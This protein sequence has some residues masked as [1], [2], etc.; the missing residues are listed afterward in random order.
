MALVHSFCSILVRLS[1]IL[2]LFIIGISLFSCTTHKPQEHIVSWN[3]TPDAQVTYAILLLEQSIRLG[4]RS[5]VLEAMSILAKNKPEAQFFTDSAAWL[6][7]EKDHITARE[8]L[9]QGVQ[10]FPDEFGLYLLLTECFLEE[11]QPVKALEI[12]QIY[13]QKH[14][15]SDLV[16]QEIGI[17]YLKMGRYKDAHQI[18][19]SLPKTYHNAFIRY[20]HA[21]ALAALGNTLEAINELQLAVKENPEFMEAWFDIGKLLEKTEKYTEA[22]KVYLDLLD[23][24]ISNQSVCLHLIRSTLAGRNPDKALTY[25]QTG[26]Q[27]Y[28]FQLAAIA[29]FIDSKFYNQAEELLN[30]MREQSD[31]PVDINFFLAAIAYEYHNN[32]DETLNFLKQ[33]P[34]RSKYYDNALLMQAQILYSQNKID[35]TLVVLRQGKDLSLNERELWIMELHL[36]LTEKR[37]EETLDT[38]DKGLKIFSEERTLLFL[39]GVALNGL[40]KKDEALQLMEKV[41][42]LYPD[43]PEVLNFVGYTLVEENRDLDRALLLIEKANSLMPNRAYIID[44]LA[45]VLFSK[46]EL[47]KAWVEINRA[48]QLEDSNDPTIWEHYGD[49]AFAMGKTKFAKIGWEKALKLQP[50]NPALIENKLKGL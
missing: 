4:D 28:G 14:P 16:R 9:I 37:Y 50:Q 23:K 17:L 29:L 33:I 42:Y 25:M 44:S 39:K 43:Y 27:N 21:Q 20:C 32:L 2:L 10:L 41:I 12:L 22:T 15:K 3:L 46:G 24:D 19:R 7:L 5:G 49:I 34:V 30:K 8:I 35:E 1:F 31:C 6:L 45:W 40:G 38:A 18:F 48:T 26:P 47:K 13:Q 36:L 11:N